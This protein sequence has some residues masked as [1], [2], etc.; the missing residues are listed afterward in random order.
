MSGECPVARSSVA[1]RGKVCAF[2]PD[3]ATEIMQQLAECYVPT[4]WLHGDDDDNDDDDLQVWTRLDCFGVHMRF[5]GSSN[6]RPAQRNHP[7]P[8]TPT[9]RCACALCQ[10]F[11]GPSPGAMASA[12]ASAPWQRLGRAEVYSWQRRVQAGIAE[13]LGP[14]AM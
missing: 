12:V 1:T 7:T 11:Q 10:G 3:L 9:R 14:M 4:S 13:G 8:R 5:R 2:E 6:A